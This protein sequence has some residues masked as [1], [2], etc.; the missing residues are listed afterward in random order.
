MV[1]FKR[2]RALIRGDSGGDR[3]TGGVCMARSGRGISLFAAALVFWAIC[4]SA[5][6]EPRTGA[7]QSADRYLLFSGVELWKAGGFLHGG[8]VWSPDGLAADGFALKLLSGAGRYHYLSGATDITG[9][10]MVFTAMPGW[11]I[12]RDRLEATVYA[13]FDLQRH[14]FRPDDVENQLRGLHIGTRFAGEVW[15][16]PTDATMMQAW[17][18]WSSVDAGY[19]VRGAVGWRL[20]DW[21]YLGPEAQALGDGHYRQVRVG[22]HLTAW[23][24]GAFEWTA[25]LGYASDKANGAGAYLRLGVLTRR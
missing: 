7:D 16:E 24:T 22:I 6:A 9:H 20:F 8:M 25:G 14:W 12:K 15:Y 21:F 17:A 2:E 10:A 13:G 23:H 18:T 4:A 5:S 11:H 3:L 19:S 1:Q